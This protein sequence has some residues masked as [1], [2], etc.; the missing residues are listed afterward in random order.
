MVTYNHAG[1]IAQALDSVLAQRTDFSFEIIIGDDMSGDHTIDILH[2]YAVKY[3][4]LIRLLLNKVNI[5]ATANVGNVLKAAKGKYIAMLEG[6]DYWSHTSK[7]QQQRDFL[8]ENLD[9]AICYHK[10]SMIDRHGNVVGLLPKDE[11]RVPR[12]SLKDLIV[13]DSFMATCSLMFRNKLYEYFPALYYT[14]RNMCDWPMNILNAEYGDI[15]YIDENMGVYRSSSSDTAWSSKRLG[16]IMKDAIII[17]DA[18]DAYFSYRFHNIIEYKKAQY[19]ITMAVDH[20]RFG[21]LGECWTILWKEMHHS[22]LSVLFRNRDVRR[23]PIVF[24]SGILKRYAPGLLK[25]VRRGRA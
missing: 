25:K 1:Y 20:L 6:D 7:L 24:I 4:Q 3:P 23:M 10:V 18:V 5:G 8:D 16:A 14:N 19:R 17:N 9:C 15:G 12:A 21:E 2:A 13:R 11:Y 22:G